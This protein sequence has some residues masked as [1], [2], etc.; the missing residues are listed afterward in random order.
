LPADELP[1]VVLHHGE[2][3]SA[4]HKPKDNPLS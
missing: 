2:E 4:G 3:G 1:P